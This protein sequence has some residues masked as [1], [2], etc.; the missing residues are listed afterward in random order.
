MPEENGSAN[1][2]LRMLT[3]EDIFAT[4]D[5]EER[6]VEVPEWG[7]S[8]TIRTFSRRQVAAMSKRATHKD[9]FTGKDV[10]D[11]ELLEA[12]TFTEGVIS[13]KFSLEDYEKLQDRSIAPILRIVKAIN[14]LSGMS[15]EAVQDAVK[16]T[17]G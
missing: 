10:T 7:G 16:S 13:P 1:G 8:V 4:T 12:L 15:E 6:V 17:E 11:N 3:V 14:A 9:R 5:I 2:H